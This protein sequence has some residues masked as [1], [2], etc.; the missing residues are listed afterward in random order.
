MFVGVER[1]PPPV[2]GERRRAQLPEAGHGDPMSFCRII[3]RLDADRVWRGE[4]DIGPVS[5]LCRNFEAGRTDEEQHELNGGPL[6]HGEPHEWISQ[7]QRL[8]RLSD[9][10][11][12]SICRRRVARY[13]HVPRDLGGWRSISPR[14][15]SPSRFR[16]GTRSVSTQSMWSTA[17]RTFG[18]GSDRTRITT[19]LLATRR[20]SVIS[21]SSAIGLCVCETRPKSSQRRPGP[22]RHRTNLPRPFPPSRIP[23]LR[24]TLIPL[25]P[26][27]TLHE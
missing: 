6:Q 22:G 15:R 17:G 5:V 13:G 14:S 3:Q 25:G 21:V 1:N 4:D 7:E 26:I 20:S 24:S 2:P 27:L 16:S 8:A 23:S 19:S 9:A 18:T 12:V 10:H 11:A